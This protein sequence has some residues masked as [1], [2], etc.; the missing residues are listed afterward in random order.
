MSSPFFL[1]VQGTSLTRFRVSYGTLVS[2]YKNAGLE[3]PKK[4][5]AASATDDK[6]KGK[7]KKEH[8]DDK[9]EKARRERSN[10]KKGLFGVKWFRVGE[11]SISFRLS[12][13]DTSRTVPES[14]R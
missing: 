3:P 13:D 10:K 12:G 7:V 2:D 14:T 5:K 9:D 4:T 1:E 8:Q 6:G 11:S